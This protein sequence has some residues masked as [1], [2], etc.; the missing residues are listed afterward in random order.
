MLGADPSA[1]D[2]DLVL[3]S[4]HNFFRQLS[5]GTP[6]SPPRSPCDQ[7]SFGLT[8]AVGVHAR[9]LPRT[10]PLPLLATKLV[11]MTG[12]GPALFHDLLSDDDLLT[13]GSSVGDV[14]SLG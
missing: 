9:E 11:G 7:F 4:L 6:L 2:V 1:S 10:M 8:N 12:Y 13:E 5:G 14:S 3:F